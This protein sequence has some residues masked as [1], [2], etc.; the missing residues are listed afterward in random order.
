MNHTTEEE[1][2]IKYKEGK[3]SPEEKE[4]VEGWILNGADFSFDLTDEELLED[5]MS[6]R[7][8]LDLDRPRRKIITLKKL[9]IA[10]SIV[11]IAALSI[12][13]FN[14]NTKQQA[15]PKN[16]VMNDKAPG[17][18][19][20]TLT[21]SDG[22]TVTLDSTANGIIKET[23]IEI[24]NDTSGNL[25]YIVKDNSAAN[26]SDAFNTI[27]T[28]RGG[29]YK[30]ILPDGSK[31]WLN[32]A[33]SLRFP[34]SFSDDS[35]KVELTGEGYFEVAKSNKRFKVTANNTTVEV[36]GTHFNVN[37]YTNEAYLNITLLEGSVKVTKRNSSVLLKPGEQCQA[38]LSTTDLNIKHDVNLESVVAWKDGEFKF[39]NTDLKNIMRQLERWYD[40]DIDENSIPNKK[41]RGTISR[42]A[43]LSEVLSMIELTSNLDFKIEGRSVIMQ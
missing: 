16:F 18:N 9:S 14:T 35:R 40:V 2:L 10:A 19:L 38:S 7:K 26:R 1:I 25:T 39:H 41:F 43:K 27:S 30:I 23:G 22:T 21:L 29:T 13:I 42:D 17:E 12:F 33:S 6:I 8:R 31:V 28:P 4:L 34:L 37:S 11:L 15:K 24:A 3:A 20:A 36:L 32:A 5:L